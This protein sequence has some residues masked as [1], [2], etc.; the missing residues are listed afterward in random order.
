MT[1]Q[2]YENESGAIDLKRFKERFQGSADAYLKLRLPAGAIFGI[3]EM[4]VWSTF[5]RGAYT[6]DTFWR[7]LPTSQR[8]FYSGSPTWSGAVASTNG[9][10]STFSQRLAYWRGQY[11]G[12]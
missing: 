8:E 9:M 5:N 7:E 10:V 11:V 1:F 6:P 4:S 3:P 12:K 2:S